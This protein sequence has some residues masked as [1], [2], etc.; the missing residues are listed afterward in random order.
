MASIICIFTVQMFLHMAFMGINIREKTG[1]D[2]IAEFEMLFRKYYSDLVNYSARFTTDIDASEEIVQDFFYNLWKNRKT[3]NIRLSVKAYFYRSVKNNTLNYLD[4][5]NVRRKYAD[6]V[7]KM[8]KG[9]W[10]YEDGGMEFSEL[11][12]LVENTLD[13]LPERCRIIFRMSRFDGLKHDEIA[14]EL[15]VSVKTVEA[16]IGKALKLLRIRLDNYTRSGVH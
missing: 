9:Q 1:N 15:S 7:L 4:A 8:S 5:L 10:G 11:N 12:E 3:T 14:K 6:R 13:E 2:D 16:N